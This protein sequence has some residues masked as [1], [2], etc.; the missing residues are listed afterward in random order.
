MPPDKFT[1]VT[2]C[3]GRT[4]NGYEVVG[5]EI[6]G[7]EIVGGELV[8]G[9]KLS[10]AKLSGGEIAE[11]EVSYNRPARG[12]LN[13]EMPKGDV[14]YTPKSENCIC[15][16]LNLPGVQLSPEP[17]KFRNDVILSNNYRPKILF[18]ILLFAPW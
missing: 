12:R 17:Q 5:V 18:P 7:G 1:P 14:L 15:Q 13:S 11:G 9:V 4:C 10:G 16:F 3:W 2:S 8:T 6:Y